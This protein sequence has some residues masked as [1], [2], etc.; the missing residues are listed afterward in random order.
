[1]KTPRLQIFLRSFFIQALW[2]FERL[3]NLGFLFAMEPAL[4][5]CHPEG[6]K[7]CKAYQG[8]L[9]YF[10]TQPYMVNWILGVA[11]AME[12]ENPQ[13]VSSLKHSLG[14]SL[15]ALGDAFFW[16]SWRPLCALCIMVFWGV[17]GLLQTPQALWLGLFL[18]LV[19]Y[20]APLLLM[21]WQAFERALQW[22]EG[23]VLE[24]KRQQ[25]PRRTRWVRNLGFLVGICVCGLAL[26]QHPE[27]F[28]VFRNLFA[29]ACFLA[30][31][32]AG[33]ST[34]TVLGYTVL[35]AIFLGSLGW[36]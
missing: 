36:V 1:M 6:E 26:A 32:Q 9:E 24:L 20:N 7:G 31:K 18:G 29:L 21:R 14:A 3:Q 33:F 13:K 12:E 34:K 15:A 8:H 5:A 11:V 10:N 30:F 16:G 22:K 4:K 27:P 2:N 17:L 23:L 19:L 28:T 25:W 35:L